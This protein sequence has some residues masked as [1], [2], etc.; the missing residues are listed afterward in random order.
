MK[1]AEQILNS[2]RCRRTAVIAINLG[3]NS[4]TKNM[5]K[6]IVIFAGKKTNL[7]LLNPHA[8]TATSLI[9]ISWSFR[10]KNRLV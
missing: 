9:K 6:S 3:K 1:G 7:H 10:Y 2:I 5:K 8:M 4:Q